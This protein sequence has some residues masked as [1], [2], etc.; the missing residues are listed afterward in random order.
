[1]LSLAI[2]SNTL[3]SKYAFWMRDKIYYNFHC[4]LN[5]LF[6]CPLHDYLVH[7]YLSLKP[8]WNV[9]EVRYWW[10]KNCSLLR[11]F[12]SLFLYGWSTTGLTGGSTTRERQPRAAGTTQSCLVSLR[13]CGCMHEG[14][15]RVNRKETPALHF[16]HHTNCSHFQRRPLLSSS[17]W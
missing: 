15:K 13:R 5:Y 4:W 17:F 16:L 11:V 14:G 2:S 7:D 9:T 12:P 8:D 10:L 3:L 1:M 6:R